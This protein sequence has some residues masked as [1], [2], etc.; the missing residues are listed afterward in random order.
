MWHVQ[1]ERAINNLGALPCNE[2]RWGVGNI[3]ITEG[4]LMIVCMTEIITFVICI[5]R[6]RIW[7][8]YKLTLKIYFFSKIYIVKYVI[9]ILVR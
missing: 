7:N 6:V 8:T 5:N 2:L 4:L 3:I 1:W 9:I